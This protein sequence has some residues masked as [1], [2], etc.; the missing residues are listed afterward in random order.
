MSAPAQDALAGLSR[1][2]RA[3]LFERL[4]Q[5]KEAAGA[6]P[7]I[8]R[9]P[10]GL[11]PV[12]ASFAQERLW[13]LDRLHPGS[14]AYNIPD[15][16]RIH[17]QGSPSL[18][19]A[20]LGEVVRRHEALRTVF[21]ERGG[22]PV[23]VVAAAAPW[24]LP[25][26]DLSA[27]P[28]GE[29][30]DE[31]RRL[32][33]AEAGR[34]F[35]LRRGPLLRASLLRLG[36]ADH[37][38][39]LIMHHIVSDGWSMGVL[40]DEITALYGALLTGRPSPLPELPI[41]YPDFAVW[42]REW[43]QDEVLERQLSY[44]R[45]HLAGA[46]ALELPTDRPRPLLQSYRG[47]Q[48]SFPFGPGFDREPAR[49]ARSFEATPFMVLLAGL[50]ALLSRLSGQAD[51]SV[52]SPI[53]NRNRAEVEPLIG[54]FVNTLVM[55]GDLSG[56]PTFRELVAR[57]R[58]STLDAYAHQ[59]LPF[60][61]LVQS[62]QPERRLST[63]PLFQVLFALQNT[64]AGRADLPGLSLSRL[65][66]AAS[67]TRFD[68]E[69]NG[70][71]GEAG[72]VVQIFYGTDLFDAATI[73]R[74]AA[75]MESLLGAAMAD[76]GLPL[77]ELPL[78]A[79]AERHQVAVEW[80]DTTAAYPAAASIPELFAEQA[81]RT[82]GAV[83]VEQGEERLTYGEL[84]RR[85]GRLARR[86]AALGLRP[87]ERV[88]V[89][90]ERSPGLI[91]ALLGVLRAGGA[92]LPL[93]TSYPPERLAWM[94]AD[95]GISMLVADGAPE[96]DLPAGLRRVFLDDE[97][98]AGALDDPP[99]VP[100]GSLAYVMYTSGSTGRPKGVAVT[101]RN[102]V[103]LVRG[104]GY[105]DL[106]PDQ[107][108]LQYS[109]I[110]FDVTTLEIWAPLLNGGRLVLFPG[111]M[112]S[113]DELAGVIARHGVTTAWLTAG[114]FHEMVDGCL[115][116]L[117]PLSQ[118]LAGGDVV[119]AEHARRALE[120]HPGLTL[121][122]GYGPTEN[123]TFTSCQRLTDPRQVG[124]SVPIGRP[125]SNSRV[126]VLDRQL[127]PSP[128]G[129]WGEL[130]AGGD[131]VARGY[132]DR[133]ELTAERFLPDAWSGE[134][135]A[136]LYRTG[137][138][139]RLRPDGALEFQ[140]R[141][142]AQVKVR[143]F[144][145]E[146]GEV[147]AALLAC[148]GVLRAAV[149]A[150]VTVTAAG[151][152]GGKSLV[153]YW[154]G[155]AREDELRLR[156]RERL[157]EPW[158]P[159]F[160]VPLPDLPLTPNGKVDRAA[161]GRL[162]LQRAGSGSEAPPRTPAE[163]AMAGLWREVLGVE[164]IGRDDDFFALGGHSLLATQLVSRVRSAFRVELPLRQVFSSPTLSG[165]AAA[166]TALGAFVTLDSTPE[167]PRR[168]PGLD[169]VPASFAQERLWFVDRLQPG[170]PAY[171][172][173]Q[174]LRIQGEA[175][176]SH[177]AG[178]LGEVVRR[179]E[180]LRT[181]FEERGGR[182]VQVVAPPGRWELPLVD[183]SALAAERRLSEAQRLA[184]EESVRRFDLRR[185]PLL[186]ASLLRLGG[187]DHALLLTLHHIVSD[188]WSMGVL[189]G[190]IT[191][192]YGAVLAGRPS[193]LPEL[194]I[195]YADFAVWQRA[196]LTA[197]ELERQLSYWRQRLA[198]APEAL[199]LPA[200][201]PRPAVPSYRG[202]RWLSPLDAELSGRLKRLALR[203]EATPFMVAL[204]GFQA[205]LSRL[206][207]QRDLVVGSPIA[208]RNREEIEPLIGFFVNTLVLRGDL[209]GDPPFGELLARTRD[210]TLEAYAH[211]DLP[212][213]TLVE[214]LRPQR[215][216]AVN[217][218]FQV[219]CA[220]QNAPAGEGD[221]PG[222]A[223]TPVSLETVTAQFDFELNVWETG[224]A[225]LAAFTYATDL[226]DAAT[227]RRIA[228]H[229]TALLAAVAE[230]D[231]TRLSALP[232]LAAGER[233]QLLVEWNDTGREPRP[234]SVVE[235]FAMQAARRPEALALEVALEAGNERLSY[236]GLDRRAGRLA[237]R[238][239][240]LG[241]GPGVV[242]GLFA[243][244]SAEMVA[245]LLATW[246][247]G[248]ACLPL[249]PG[250]P[251]ARLAW[252]LEDSGAA[253]VAAGS[254]LAGSLP[255]H[256]ARVLSL[257]DLEEESDVAPA[258]M[259]Q[260]EDLAYL[261]YTSGTTGH[262]KAV[263][264]EHRHLASTLAAVQEA[265]GF[266][267]GDRMP[268]LASFSFDIFLFE[269]L[270][271]L[272]AGG[273]S[274]LLPLRPTLDFERLAG[275]L[276]TA[277]LLH[278]VPAVMRQVV[279]RARRRGSPAAPSSLRALFTGGDAV[280]A[281][282][283][284]DLRETFP[285]AA[286]HELYGPTEA[287]IVCAA[288][289]VPAEGPVRSL[290]GRP[291]PG[292]EI[293]LRD[294]SGS[295]VPVGV[296]GE[297]W[298]GGSG[299]S[300]GYRRREELT[301]EKF[302][303]V[304]GRR[305]FRSGDRARRL[306]D[307]TLEFLGRADQQV[308]VRGFRVELG[309]VEGALLRR[310]EVEQ[311]VVAA[312]EVTPGAGLQLAAYV[313]ARPAAVPATEVS[314]HVSQWQA[315]YD[316]T[317][318]RSAAA[319]PTF[320][321]EGWNSSYTGEPIPVG[322][323]REWVERTVE[324]I[325]SLLPAAGGRVLEV[326]CGTGLILFRVAPHC[327]RYRATDFSPVVL[328]RLRRRIGE[329][330]L[331]LSQ[332]ELARAAADDWSGVEPGSFD[333][334][335]LNSVAQY[336][337]DVEYLLRVLEG[338]ARAV[339]PGGAVFVGDVRNLELLE[340][341]QTSIELFRTQGAEGADGGETVESAG[342]LRSR[343]RRK[344]AD[345]EELL[346]APS[347]FPA[348]VGH[349]PGVHRAVVL[350]KEGRYRNELT[351]F[352]YDAILSV[353]ESSPGE[354]AERRPWRAY[355]NDPLRGKLARRLGPELRRALQAELPD[356]MVPACFMLLDALPLTPHGKVDRAALPAPEPRSAGAESGGPPRT[357]AEEAL[358]ALW[359]E[360]LGIE[361]FGRDDDFFALGGHS[362]LA[363]QLVS[364]L[365][366]A[367]HV[368]VPLRA[369]FE[370]PTVAA[371]AAWIGRE[372]EAAPPRRLDGLS[373]EQRSR[374]FEQI[375]K[376]RESAEP[377]PDRIPR[378]PPGAEP[379]PASFAQERLWFLDRLEPGNTAFNM[380]TSLRLA[381][382]LDGPALERALNEIVRRHEALRT[383]FVEIDGRPAQRILPSLRVPWAV[384]DLAALPEAA[385]ESEADRVT[386]ASLASPFD[387]A[388]GPLLRASLL[389]LAPDLHLF[390]LEIHHI[391][392]DGWSAGV[393]NREL[394]DL[395]GAFAAG[396]PSPL[397]P[398]PIQYGD[399]ARWQREWLRG[400]TLAAQLAYW[401]DKLGGELAPLDLPADRPRPAVQTFRGGDLR[402]EI[403]AAVAGALRRLSRAGGASL[404]M[405][406]LAAFQLLLARLSGQDDVVVGSPIAG[407]RHA[408][409][410]GL[411][412]F[413]LNT[414]A[415]RTSVAGNPSFREL[416]DRARE[417]TLGAFTHQD[418]PFE[419]LLVEL[420]PERDLSRT[421]VFQVFFNL[422]NL[423]AGG[424]GLPG[425][426]IEPGPAPEPES[427]FDLTFYVAEAEEAIHFNLVYNADLFDP[428]RMEEM[429][430]QY[431]V[432]LEAAARDPERRIGDLSLVTPE[433]AAV[434]PDLA[435][436][437]GAEWR[438]AV[439]ELFLEAARRHPERA[440][441]I[442]P[443]GSWTYGELAS[444]SGRLAAHLRT[445]GLEPGDR[446]AIWAHRSAPI[447]WAVMGTLAAGGAF[448][449]LD[450]A[451]PAAR[452]VEIL[453]LAAP[454]AWLALADAG[455][456]PRE[457]EEL[458]AGW[459]AEGRLLGRLVLP[460]GGPAAAGDLLA[461]FPP[462][463]EPV[464]TGPG[465]LAFV[466]FTSGSTGI[467][468]GILGLHG[469][470]SHFLPW[471]CERFGL[472]AEDRYS[473]LSGLAHDP[474]QRD[475]F[476]SLCTGAVLCA[477]DP[478]EIFVP[479]RLAAWAA[480]QGITVA[481][482]TPALGQVLT[483]PPG[484]G[485]AATP[486][487][488]L[489]YVLLVG[490]VLTRLDVDRIHR[491]APGVTCVNLYGST[492]TQRA[493]GYHV[494]AAGAGAAGQR[495]RQ[496]LPLGLG[497]EDVQ[498]LVVNASGQLAGV[499]EL[500]E[501]WMR[502]PHLARG[503]LGDEALTRERFLLNPFTDPT[504]GNGDRVYRTGDLGRYL[505]NG[506]AV[507]AGRVDQ[508]VKIRGF[509]IEMGEIQATIGRLEGVRESVVVLREEQGNRYLA[510]YVVPEPGAEPGLAGR[511]RPF[512]ASRL[513]DYMV[514]AAFVELPALPLTPNG[515]VDRRALPAPERP[516]LEPGAA[517]RSPLEARLA[518]LWA[519]LLPLDR[520]GARVGVHDNFFELGGH[521]LLATQLVS[522]VRAAFGVELALRQLFENPTLE[523]LAAVISA[524]GAA[525]SE[526]ILRRPPGIDPIPASFAQ[527][528]MW[529]L[530]RLQP[531]N[532]A[533]NIPYALRLLGELPVPLLEAALGEV[534]RRHESLRTTF[535]DQGGHPVQVI[536]P[537]G[538]WVLP[539][540]DLSA[541][542]EG[543]RLSEL[544]DLVQE[545]AALPFDLERGPLLRSALVRVSEADHGLLVTLHHAISD[546]WSVGVMIREI[547]A[548]FAAALAGRPSP[549]PALA[550][551]YADFAVWQREWLA[552]E[553][554]SASSP[555]GGGGWTALRPRST[556]RPTGRARRRRPT[557][558][559]GRSPAS[560]RSSRASWRGS[561]CAT[562]RPCSW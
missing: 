53:A 188:G 374:V 442:D 155:E 234:W 479:G 30:L 180:A 46:A 407:R 215:H 334:V 306:P 304:E 56:D 6:P 559:R 140:G 228:G 261:I 295:P 557:G 459:E 446:V 308:K 415:L 71:Q 199:D 204:A 89:L 495:A 52:G 185:G 139:V 502:S 68:L 399:F 520:V 47:A 174:A 294:A 193:P 164:R 217:P 23:Q 97:E 526:V 514:P 422:M 515:K 408:E 355:A 473:L 474:L 256:G 225:L 153:A 297:I 129:V 150:V 338:A 512:L 299:V 172:I 434:L 181:T 152:A 1:E 312:R 544:R 412:G 550:I 41:Q 436:P 28:E 424:S 75:Q 125:I 2:Q 63:T 431:R 336:F 20:I 219:M 444:A 233:H 223:L 506:E 166:V 522:R 503:Y 197:E 98:P 511:L 38:L 102:V 243:E 467:P 186:R 27:L 258:G 194:P 90:A 543:R 318:G 491:L 17:G 81:A 265:F 445:G 24:E 327:E 278:A 313:V 145:V 210:A 375:R 353:G 463:M 387:L 277:T 395:Y 547:M 372:P 441:V 144:R 507:F 549:L 260:P 492:E 505:P 283:L 458:L 175:S 58:R 433:A 252:M 419:A 405:T 240:R 170:N 70:W 16:L 370:T 392:S 127:Q 272:L 354:P 475:L 315:L 183:L 8:P 5:R 501:I 51:L 43:L 39:L 328:D 202:A 538:R 264:V 303:E 521:S 235:R 86:L 69:L 480:R 421:P 142:D 414:L 339:R 54:L 206:T 266:G 293:Q 118:L 271:P 61:Q 132:L 500:G 116:G 554:W 409:T 411:I 485:A 451:Y 45:R 121:I 95:A 439:H 120:A 541:L 229:F 326:G 416:L 371:L 222:L 345:E 539:Q 487:P 101:H 83:A 321:V 158:I 292:V 347:L 176:P 317:Y 461:A 438:G 478:E 378:R 319:D 160:F 115:E 450:P 428:P 91:V 257:E 232:L 40:V 380:G 19:A 178:I 50:Q 373:R 109:A 104:A 465:D 254:G 244:R 42:Q 126:Y 555:T 209:T 469:P 25:L 545:E 562:R 322:E 167:L 62:L 406:L 59:D 529:L 307:G 560:T 477:P 275:E 247:A 427:K 284:V 182:P 119:S 99:A 344:I 552:G 403:P 324:R 533:Y 368:E 74:L 488:S 66:L 187:R 404:F 556:C 534:V 230:D 330:G 84:Q 310:A 454:R 131:G 207:G 449:M 245:G 108:W 263:E 376:H 184:Q 540:V 169:P 494:V 111:R 489:R 227:V 481:H 311:A 205:L 360:L 447:S 192:L 136:R 509:R 114:L 218:L 426:E 3:A 31:M 443:Q 179:H 504:G 532:P 189:V 398:L 468:K 472:A 423:P 242:V 214:R 309:E 113:L 384:V 32:A 110:A 10:P 246:R 536:A 528:R 146:P 226:F 148:P 493:V 36:A 280:P 212:F 134:P 9:R 269:L 76:P 162:E 143:G 161:L 448:V 386:R 301:A 37:A 390:V 508:Q 291:F 11:D 537:A 262:P 147:E 349:L 476:T 198:G 231:G 93:D 352:R 100:A 220:V 289:T 173:P 103:R 196:W 535:R 130:F 325:L 401:R 413:F 524:Q 457:V 168:L 430:R 48:L 238:L 402:M 333:L 154:V 365:R 49:V 117:A 341:L 29:R 151:P 165:L 302:V 510:A 484:D 72:L 342:E 523:R 273:A 400:E 92:Y 135:G 276:E 239:R 340:E 21:E 288:W 346:L 435:R 542:P 208:N 440:A 128:P 337:P 331:D 270:G 418:I 367:F 377:P 460:G 216:L 425:L 464:A 382:R 18:L 57:V 470:L 558:A 420:K 213:E 320:D 490:D 157:P 323:M 26:V 250:L 389:R 4:R 551:Q 200:D 350:P 548:L 94:A 203:R 358:A 285:R 410:E 73:R 7:R 268:C 156:L 497:M 361:R 33:H 80:N 486:V 379:V 241:V 34:P 123:T 483:E 466:A 105:A 65:E 279:D 274:V 357:P 456:L 429:L 67:A 496:V 141:I 211:Q 437:L 85:S 462:R 13:F 385:R 64:P 482:L 363:T 163:R 359:R 316:E 12:P 553:G 251:A 138:L 499:G 329:S 498:V 253:V 224:G 561:P 366:D 201:R 112:G 281:D 55:R 518:E 78:L 453:R 516:D 290:L 60:D 79:A 236:A 546:G 195:Q 335:V 259:P 137:D 305:F 471:Q 351:R 255:P 396:E 191:A 35:D 394:V 22:Q 287:A 107:T 96:I 356:Y 15:A 519:E 248:G 133:P 124:E 87:E 77:S 298:I 364:R 362:L 282:L 383:S 452:L 149:I 314:E 348:L 249:D 106:G 525:G 517:P 122:D 159:S 343:V 267:P 221:L 286:V 391:V 388:A 190:E 296:P 237:S 513:P 455:G 44:W 82:P 530:D 177:L 14:A 397:P 417:T 432:V 300:R 88:A 527:E 369:V 381:G 171:N 393:M 332:V 531:G